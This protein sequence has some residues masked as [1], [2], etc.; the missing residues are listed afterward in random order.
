MRYAVPVKHLLLFLSSDAVVLVQ[1][2]E[3]GT[4]GLF[5]RSIRTGFE[6]SQVGEDAFFK[7][8]GVFDRSTEGL[9]AERKASYDVSARNVEKVVPRPWSESQ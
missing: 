3:E 6:V 2:I 1:E 5:Q 7:L 4:L 9:K 8:F